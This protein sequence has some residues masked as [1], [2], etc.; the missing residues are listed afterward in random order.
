VS[1]PRSIESH[2]TVHHG[3]AE[4]CGQLTPGTRFSEILRATFPPGSVTG[5]PKIRAMQVIDELEHSP[6]GPYCGAVGCLSTSGDLRLGVSIRT[7]SFEGNAEGGFHDVEG[8]L[9]YGTGCGIV[10]D[11]DPADEF[12]ESQHKTTALMKLLD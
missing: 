4:I 8:R 6:R 1:Q 11:S 7:A 10:V 2:P 3:V 9:V 5:A 12:R